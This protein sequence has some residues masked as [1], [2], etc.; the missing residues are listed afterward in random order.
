MVRFVSEASA[1]APLALLFLDLDHFKKVNDEAGHTAGD[2]VLKG[3]VSEV[4]AAASGKGI[5]YR[6]GGDEFVVLLP[7]YQ[8]DEALSLAERICRT[9]QRA[10]LGTEFAR[11]T[12]SIGVATYPGTTDKAEHLVEQADTAMYAAKSNGGNRARKESQ[13]PPATELP[14]K[15]CHRAQSDHEAK[16]G[17]NHYAP[18]I[19]SSGVQTA[20]RSSMHGV[21]SG[22]RQLRPSM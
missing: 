11:V 21:Y 13:E 1:D 3:V 19:T 16:P 8:E 2:N 14:R 17:R 6:D 4:K 10:E 5:C 18:H 12:V 20:P 9:V 7:N 15:S 22:W